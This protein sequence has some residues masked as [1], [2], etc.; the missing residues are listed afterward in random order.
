M[1]STAQPETESTTIAQQNSDVDLV[2]QIVHI[3]PV[4]KAVA[5]LGSRV[6]DE[7]PSDSRDEDESPFQAMVWDPTDATRQRLLNV[8][9]TGVVSPHCGSSD[10]HI[11]GYVP[12][13]QN[14]WLRRFFAG[15]PECEIVIEPSAAPL[16]RGGKTTGTVTVHLC[17]NDTD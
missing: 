12:L 11:V 6:Y 3:E 16:Q 13:W 15:R 2:L 1:T 7:F 8:H 14:E 17:R 5:Q 10:W 9:V 4:G